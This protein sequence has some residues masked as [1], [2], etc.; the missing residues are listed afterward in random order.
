VQRYCHCHGNRS[1]RTFTSLANSGRCAHTYTHAGAT[2][3][4]ECIGFGSYFAL[5]SR[6]PARVWNVI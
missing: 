4:A 3:F 2:R 5:R 1:H 6:P